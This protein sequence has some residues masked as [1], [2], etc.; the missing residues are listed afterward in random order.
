MLSVVACA[1]VYVC[2][3]CGGSAA[4]A[5]I[6]SRPARPTLSSSSVAAAAASRSCGS[7]SGDRSRS[8]SRSRCRRNRVHDQICL[9]QHEYANIR[10]TLSKVTVHLKHAN[11][12]TRDSWDMDETVEQL[13]D[14]I[15][16]IEQRCKTALQAAEQA[17]LAVAAM[18]VGLPHVAIQIA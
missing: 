14:R 1:T 3:E 13:Q 6:P 2:P 11:A 7:G 16:N 5:M 15:K 4:T 12:H 18:V 8:R 17:D 9:L 10:D